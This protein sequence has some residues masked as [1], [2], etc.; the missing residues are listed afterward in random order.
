MSPDISLV[1]LL[2]VTRE[3]GQESLKIQAM[4]RGGLLGT[5]HSWVARPV[6]GSS[7]DAALES[8]QFVLSTIDARPSSGMLAVGRVVSTVHLLMEG[9]YNA[10]EDLLD[11]VSIDVRVPATSLLWGAA[12]LVMGAVVLSSLWV[13]RGEC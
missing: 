2:Q 4:M 8:S 13:H 1:P 9:I 12:G 11:A 7:D 3:V 5:G 10:K 6:P